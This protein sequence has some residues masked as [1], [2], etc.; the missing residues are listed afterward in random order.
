[1]AGPVR[2][3]RC[4]TPVAT[5][6]PAPAPAPPVVRFARPCY[7][8][9]GARRAGLSWKTLGLLLAA[10]VAAF[11]LLG[12]YAQYTEELAGHANPAGAR[13]VEESR[14]QLREAAGRNGN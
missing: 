14:R 1:V 4:G 3:P 10:L 9:I 13:M 11:Y 12:A 5:L 6:V 8:P 7:R 2:C